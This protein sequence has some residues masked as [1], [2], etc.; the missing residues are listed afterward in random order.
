MSRV[1][2][3]PTA[4]RFQL[5]ANSKMELM[6]QQV[7]QEKLRRRAKPFTA[8]MPFTRQSAALESARLAEC[9]VKVCIL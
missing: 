3:Q 5:R 2:S 7:E 1:A 8:S 4:R 9:P 6:K